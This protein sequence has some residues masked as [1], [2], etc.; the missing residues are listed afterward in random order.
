MCIFCT[1]AR[2]VMMDFCTVL[3][4]LPSRAFGSLFVSVSVCSTS[5]YCVLAMWWAEHGHCAGCQGF[6]RKSEVKLPAFQ[7]LE[8]QHR[9]GNKSRSKKHS[10][11]VQIRKKI[12]QSRTVQLRKKSPVKASLRGNPEGAG[13]S[14]MR[15]SQPRRD[16]LNKEGGNCSSC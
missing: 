2:V 4:P 3:R 13:I 1:P 14:K 7:E 10:G 8:V 11:G 16:L 5:V 12:S 6:H 15:R 9:Q